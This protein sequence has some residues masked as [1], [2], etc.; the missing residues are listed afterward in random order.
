MI[1]KSCIVKVSVLQ[2]NIDEI[3]CGGTQSCDHMLTEM[4]S[5]P[6]HIASCRM[7]YHEHI[8]IYFSAILSI[9]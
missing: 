2:I 4:P 1:N 8:I 9:L 7:L 6:Y 3:I 5:E